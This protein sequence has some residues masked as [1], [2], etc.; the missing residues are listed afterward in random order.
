MSKLINKVPL[1]S[2]VFDIPEQPRV[3]GETSDAR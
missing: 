2:R 3:A 1:L